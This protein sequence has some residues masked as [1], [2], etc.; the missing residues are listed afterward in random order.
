[1]GSTFSNSTESAPAYGN[2]APFLQGSLVAP[3]DSLV[4]QWR[5]GRTLHKS[6][7]CIFQS[8]WLQCPR[9]IYF[10]CA[11]RRSSLYFLQPGEERV[12]GRMDV[13]YSFISGTVAASPATG[14][15][16][17]GYLTWGL[18]S[19]LPRRAGDDSA[20]TRLRLSAQLFHFVA[21]TSASRSCCQ[22]RVPLLPR[23]VP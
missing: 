6:K 5:E 16:A 17:R 14:G 3:R 8:T 19:P 10:P 20:N 9:I 11:I 21:L 23:F 22:V 4:P 2:A 13:S 15:G 7:A 1:M 18:L 12:W